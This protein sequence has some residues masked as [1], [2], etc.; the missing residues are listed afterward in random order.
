MEMCEVMLTHC[1][2]VHIVDSTQLKRRMKVSVLANDSRTIH[3][4]NINT[5]IHARKLRKIIRTLTCIYSHMLYDTQIHCIT[6][7]CGMCWHMVHTSHSE[8]FKVCAGE[9][10]QN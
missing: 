9:I 2:V 8:D 6:T 4:T 3:N 1:S 5:H 10:T 7:Y